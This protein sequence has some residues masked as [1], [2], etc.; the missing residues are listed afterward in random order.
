VI[1]L[2][3]RMHGTR[4]KNLLL[5]ALRRVARAWS[6]N[7]LK[8][9]STGLQIWRA[10]LRSDYDTFWEE[11]GGTLGPDRMYDIP[12]SPDFRPLEEIA[13]KKRAMYRNRYQFLEALGQEIE[14][15]LDDTGR[16]ALVLEVSR[17]AAVAGTREEK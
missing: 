14:N 17:T 6:I 2:T 3:R 15:A 9:V 1:A 16:A 8:A 5:F 7:R 4:P 13:A 11:I 10:K 12:S